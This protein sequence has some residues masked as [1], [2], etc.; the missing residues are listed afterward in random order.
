MD[1]DVIRG[2][3]RHM[4]KYAMKKQTKIETNHIHKIFISI[5]LLKTLKYLQ[6]FHLI[7]TEPFKKQWNIDTLGAPVRRLAL[8]IFIEINKHNEFHIQNSGSHGSVD[9][10]WLSIKPMRNLHFVSPR[11]NLGSSE[12]TN[13]YSE[14]ICI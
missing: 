5:N 6:Q 10:A 9:F 14:A 4:K 13:R 11:R 12:T 3:T 1:E 7:R 8:S 2:I